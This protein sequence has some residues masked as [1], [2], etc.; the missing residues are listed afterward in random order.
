MLKMT[1]TS[2]SPNIWTSQLVYL[3]Q[4]SI[5]RSNTAKNESL[6]LFLCRPSS[7]P[8]SYEESQGSHQPD[9]PDESMEVVVLV[10]GLDVVVSLAPPLYSQD[11]SQAPDCTW[12]WELPPPYSQVDSG[13]RPGG[14]GG[15]GGEGRSV[16]EGHV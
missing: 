15:G 7:F 10:D 4:T 11:S 2:S 16:E 6:L 1:N 5:S 14:R 3:L 12:S 8:P 9:R 13:G